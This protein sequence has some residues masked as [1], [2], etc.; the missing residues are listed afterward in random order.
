LF[1]EDEVAK[2]KLDNPMLDIESVFISY[3]TQYALKE[4]ENCDFKSQPKLKTIYNIWAGSNDYCHR[5][6]FDNDYKEKDIVA[7][8][9]FFR[10]MLP[11]KFYREIDMDRELVYKCFTYDRL[12][13][14]I[15]LLLLSI[16]NPNSMIGVEQHS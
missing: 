5:K 13:R 10:N 16:M 11:I 9:E 2:L 14:D 12:M 4:R 1:T 8:L 6:L 15:E 7:F 3:G